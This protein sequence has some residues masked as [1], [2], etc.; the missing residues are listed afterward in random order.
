MCPIQ[1]IELVAIWRRHGFSCRYCFSYY[2]NECTKKKTNEM[3]KKLVPIE[4]SNLGRMKLLHELRRN[5]PPDFR[6]FLRMDTGS[7]DELLRMR[8]PIV[9]NETIVFFSDDRRYHSCIRPAC[10]KPSLL[11]NACQLHCDHAG[12][13][14]RGS[15]VRQRDG[16][17]NRCI[18]QVLTFAQ[19]N[20]KRNLID[21]IQL[22][23]VC[24]SLRSRPYT[25]NSI[26]NSS[27]DNEIVQYNWSCMGAFILQFRV[28]CSII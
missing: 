11:L 8:T 20:I 18:A 14:F 15:Q 16:I 28:E 17:T 27:K 21:A 9:R 22:R 25:V 12:N 4:R 13:T 5:E 26:V 10:V 6:N 7:C 19:W 1:V 23:K 24:A 3:V 2:Y